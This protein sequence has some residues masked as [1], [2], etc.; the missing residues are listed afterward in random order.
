VGNQIICISRQWHWLC[1]QYN[2]KLRKA[3]RRRVTYSETYSEKPFISRVVPSLMDR[4]RLTVSGIEDYH[5]FTD[6][7]YSHVEFAHKLD[8][9]K[10]KYT[11]CFLTLCPCCTD[12]SGKTLH[13]VALQVFKNPCCP[14]CGN[15]SK[16]ADRKGLI[17]PSHTPLIMRINLSLQTNLTK[18]HIPNI[19]IGPWWCITDIIR[20]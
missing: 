18:Q 10:C 16:R 5:L 15:F 2:S 14:G 1:S 13:L 9:Q 20:I 12:F 7:Y 3:Y 8:N 17:L 19:C 11:A 6:R 4:L